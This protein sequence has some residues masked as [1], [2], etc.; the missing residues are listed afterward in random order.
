MHPRKYEKPAYPG[1]GIIGRSDKGRAVL[2]TVNQQIIAVKERSFSDSIVQKIEGGCTKWRAGLPLH[3]V[4]VNPYKM[5]NGGYTS[6]RERSDQPPMETGGIAKR[7]ISVT[8][9]NGGQLRLRVGFP[10]VEEGWPGIGK[11][12]SW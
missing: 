9:G 5:S 2:V 1:Y 7:T 11:S 6:M 3:R 12:T 10:R 4:M 8:I